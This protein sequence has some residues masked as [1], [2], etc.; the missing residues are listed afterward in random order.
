[1]AEMVCVCVL[2]WDMSNMI[3]VHTLTMVVCVCVE[4]K[5]ADGKCVY[6]CALREWGVCKI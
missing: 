6:V 2:R 1:M 4:V 5:V 3:N